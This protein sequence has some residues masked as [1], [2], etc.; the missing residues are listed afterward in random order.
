MFFSDGFTIYRSSDDR[1]NYYIIINHKKYEASEELYDKVTHKKDQIEKDE[2][3]KKQQKKEAPAIDF[4]SKF[5]N[6][7]K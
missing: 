3:T 2:R 4:L 1:E 7:Q 5:V 6:N